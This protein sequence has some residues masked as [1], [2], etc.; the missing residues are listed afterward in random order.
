MFDFKKCIRV[1]L[2]D[3]PCKDGDAWLITQR[4]PW[5]LFLIIPFSDIPFYDKDLFIIPTLVPLGWNFFLFQAPFGGFKSSGIGKEGSKYGLDEYS[6]RK[7]ICK[8]GL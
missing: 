8:G 7:L 1:N 2:S 5:K 4:Y 3:H 6:N